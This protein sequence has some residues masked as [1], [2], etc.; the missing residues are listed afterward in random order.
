MPRLFRLI[1]PVDDIE[2]ATQFYSQILGSPGERIWVNRHY[3]CCGDIIIACVAPPGDVAQYRPQEDPRI[4]YFAVHDLEA[5]FEQARQAGCRRVDKKI[6][7]QSWGER[8]F[9]AEDP[10]GNPLCFVDEKTRYLGGALE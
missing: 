4:L 1:V 9:Y 2:I 8:C 10:F 6:E 7:T 5:K 3:F